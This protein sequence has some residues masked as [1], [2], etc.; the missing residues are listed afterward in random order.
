MQQEYYLGLDIGT[1]SVGWAVTDKAYQLC[2]KHGK[3]LWGIRLFETANTAKER[4]L[5]RC[6]RRRLDRQNRRIQLLQEIFA[7]EITKIDAGFFWR[8]KESK[9]VPED[10]RDLDGNVPE[11][12]YMLFVDKNYTDKEFHK[13]YPTIYHLRKKLMEEDTIKDIRLVYLA[14]HHIIK[15]RGHFLFA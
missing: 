12:P 10:K 11:L 3:D 2:R 8:L 6:N 9:Y 13:E 1:G 4:R 7:E 14:L 15:H 5:F